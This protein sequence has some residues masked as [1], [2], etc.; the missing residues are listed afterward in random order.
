L[1]Q[2]IRTDF[3][4]TFFHCRTNNSMGIYIILFHSDLASFLVPW[5]SEMK[6]ESK[7]NDCRANAIVETKVNKTVIFIG[8]TALLLVT[9]TK[10]M[11]AQINKSKRAKKCVH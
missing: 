1:Q 2:L 6:T 9:R 8:S 7:N 5:F 3:A 10:E 11:D 4:E